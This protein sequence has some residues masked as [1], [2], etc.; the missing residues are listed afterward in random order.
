MTFCTSSLVTVLTYNV[1]SVFVFL[2]QQA[3]AH[4]L[5]TSPHQPYPALSLLSSTD[6]PASLTSPMDTLQSRLCTLTDCPLTPPKAP[7]LRTPYSRPSLGCSN[8]Q[9]NY[10][11][12]YILQTHTHINSKG[13]MFFAFLCCLLKM[14]GCFWPTMHQFVDFFFFFFVSLS[15]VALF[16]AVSHKYRLCPQTNFS[17]YVQPSTLRPH[18]PLLAKACHS[19]HKSFNS[20]SREKVRVR[21]FSFVFM[22]MHQYTCMMMRDKL[23][24]MPEINNID[25]SQVT[26]HI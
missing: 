14:E 8:I 2:A 10:I 15:R 25:L 13:E 19:H 18:W 26:C 4:R 1:L 11:Y 3:S 9:V 20:S 16:N 23:N 7:R 24:E 5:P 6:L 21:D 22:Y 12:K 17:L